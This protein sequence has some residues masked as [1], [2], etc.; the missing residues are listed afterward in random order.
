MFTFGTGIAN[1]SFAG[2]I[3]G[4]KG[5]NLLGSLAGGVVLDQS[6]NKGY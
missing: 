2:F 4:T 3:P 5:G 1:P 6:L